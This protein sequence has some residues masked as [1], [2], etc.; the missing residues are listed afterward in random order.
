MTLG[1]L[2]ALAVL[3]AVVLVYRFLRGWGIVIDSIDRVREFSVPVD[4]ES[5]QNLVDP[6]EAQYL[7]AHLPPR[8]YRRIQRA[9]NR[10]ALEYVRRMA[11]NAAFLLRAGDSARRSGDPRTAQAAERL[12][13]SALELR[14][15]SALAIGML[16]LRI[17]LP[18]VRLAPYS[19]ITRYGS[20]R[21]RVETLMRIQQPAAVSHLSSAL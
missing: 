8:E 2:L 18:D 17:C 7:K 19:F 1:T 10:A 6:A 20:L 13:N 5:L 21:D 4:I 11:R 16:H 3:L 15:H 12:V 14:F 9:R